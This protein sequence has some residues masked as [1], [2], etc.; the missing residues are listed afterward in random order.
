MRKRFLRAS[1]ANLGAALL[2]LAL[3]SS[4][5]ADSHRSYSKHTRVAHPSQGSQDVPKANAPERADFAQ[6]LLDEDDARYFLT[7]TGFAPDAQALAPYVGLSREQAVDML[8]AT[9]RA[10]PFT[11]MPAW[12]DEP[13][14]TRAQERALDADARRA[15]AAERG[16]R[17]EALRGWWIHEMVV[18]PSPLTERMTLFWHGHFTSAQDKVPY[19]QLMARQNALL[20]RYALGSFAQMLHAVAKDPAMLMYLDGAGNRKGHPNEN[21][22]REVMEL[23]TLGEGHYT[24][25]DVSEAARAYT[26][27]SLDPDTRAYVW[28]AEWHDAGTKTVLG[29]VGAFDGDAVLDLLLAQPQT[30]TFIVT[31]LWREFVSERPAPA[32]IEPIAARFRASGYDIAVALRGLFSTDAFW[33]ARNRGVLV[34]SPVQFV[35]GTLRSFDVDD[36]DTTP[37]AGTVRNLGQNL[38]A[39]PNVKGWPGGSTWINSTTLL[40]REQFV[41]QLFRAT[42]ASRAS[43]RTMQMPSMAGM[44]A[45]S[46]PEMAAHDGSPKMAGMPGTSMAASMQSSPSAPA[47]ARGMRFDLD[48]WLARYGT[49]PAQRPGLSVELQLQHAV[50]PI[51]P[52]DPID[53]GASSS[54]YLRALLMDPVY[55]LD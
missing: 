9:A 12:V 47:H 15:E 27:W 38:F 1:G 28:R 16:R 41:E 5:I 30:A 6:P 37:L 20:R 42:E 19:P 50:L 24:Q 46:A 36:D 52:V 35:V 31:Q 18:T 21:F 25:R 2:L 55:Q 29:Q 43:A 11:P 3:A 48:G 44:A 7:R 10:T 8:L 45:G 23:F 14:P 53:T 32:L 39:P 17:Y 49:A 34:K 26:G 4:A 40:A 22:A 51:S 13:I 54:A 33:D